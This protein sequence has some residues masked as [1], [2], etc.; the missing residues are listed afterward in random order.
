MINQ[1]V[2]VKHHIVNTGNHI[3]DTSI[4][5]LKAERE[6]GRRESQDRQ[7]ALLLTDGKLR[8]SRMIATELNRERTNVTKSLNVLVSQNICATPT[9]KKCVTT[10]SPAGHYTLTADLFNLFRTNKAEFNRELE[11]RLSADT[12]TLEQCIIDAFKPEPTTLAYKVKGGVFAMRKG[13]PVFIDTAKK[14]N[15]ETQKKVVNAGSFYCRPVTFD[16]FVGLF[17]L[18]KL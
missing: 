8:T 1:N 11:R 18:E 10:K 15:P 12:R 5:S 3:A 9:K 14:H 7:T 17:N 6:S 4:A 13:K 2:Q 16:G